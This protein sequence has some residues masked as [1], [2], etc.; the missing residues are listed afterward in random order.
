MTRARRINVIGVESGKVSGKCMARMS[1][2]VA[3]RQM[4][5]HAPIMDFRYCRTAACGSPHYLARRRLMFSATF[6][7][8]DHPEIFGLPNHSENEIGA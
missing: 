2:S 7:D 6:G 4:R 1:V 8:D 5:R 3:F